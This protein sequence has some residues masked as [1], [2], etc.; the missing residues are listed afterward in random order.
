MT[1]SFQ[2]LT[3]GDTGKGSPW[4]EHSNGTN[5]RF[6]WVT[7]L[8]IGYRFVIDVMSANSLGSEL[9]IQGAEE[10]DQSDVHT[11]WKQRSIE[12]SEVSETLRQS[13]AYNLTA[14]K[15]RQSSTKSA[16]CYRRDPTRAH[17]GP[18]VTH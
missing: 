16:G 1:G 8:G 3:D 18:S 9:F 11:F 14:L 12:A 4:V 2:K 17:E 13:T 15:R 7:P 10:S 6:P 5:L